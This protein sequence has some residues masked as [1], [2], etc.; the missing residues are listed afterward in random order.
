MIEDLDGL[1]AAGDIHTDICI[2][3]AGAAGITLALALAESGLDCCVLESG[4]S[5]FDPGIQS[6]GSLERDATDSRFD[7]H[8]RYLGGSTNHWGGWCAPL[9]TLDF[10]T[11][12]WVPAPVSATYL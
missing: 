11:R 10:E 7:C 2:V 3:G 8:L 6:L 5:A 1:E 9:N 12:A 4:G